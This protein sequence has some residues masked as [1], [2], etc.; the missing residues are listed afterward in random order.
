VVG[1]AALMRF[2][3]PVLGYGDAKKGMHL[4]FVASVTLGLGVDTRRILPFRL[5]CRP[6]I[7][8]FSDPRR[9][10]GLGSA[11]RALCD[12]VLRFLLIASATTK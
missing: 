8:L 12:L 4:V 10:I 6:C 2:G 5:Q 7:V 11:R 1:C 3:L 9:K